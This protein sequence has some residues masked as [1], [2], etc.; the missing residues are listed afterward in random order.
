MGSGRVR[1]L[2]D[3]SVW[4]RGYFEPDTI[5]DQ[6]RR[7]LASSTETF[8]LSA[9]SLWEVGKKHQLGKLPLDRDLGTWFRHAITANVDVL[10]LTQE[11]VADAMRLPEFPNRDPADELIVATARV[12]RLIL[13]TTDTHLRRYRHAKISY[14]R[15]LRPSRSPLASSSTRSRTPR[16]RADR[17]FD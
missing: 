16:Q 12:H 1:Y 10:A 6:P 4:V 9:I 17:S 14:F 3:T 15:P 7:V 11:V 8:G 5:P 2:L 13:L